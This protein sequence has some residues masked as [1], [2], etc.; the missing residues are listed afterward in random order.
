M[1]RAIRRK[2][3][4]IHLTASFIIIIAASL[5]FGAFFVSA[6]E[7]NTAEPD[8]YYKSICI[9][10]G[11]TLWDIACDN[12]TDEY[13]SIDEYIQ[14]IK[15]TN[16]LKSDSIQAGQYL[17]IKCSNWIFRL[18]NRKTGNVNKS[19]F[20]FIHSGINIHPILIYNK[21]MYTPE[22]SRRYTQTGISPAFL[23]FIYP[24]FHPSAGSTVTV[25][26]FNLYDKYR[27]FQ[28][29]WT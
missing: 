18:H 29:I 20:C 17:V 14:L 13:D 3:Q 9:Q 2:K 8:T 22:K 10:S 28:K 26:D 15:D 24:F 19:I 12:M 11:D 16:G 7:N 6:R 5:V 1:E 4:F 21:Y 25:I 27:F 23:I